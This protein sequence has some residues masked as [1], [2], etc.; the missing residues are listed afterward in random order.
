M[1][2]KLLNIEIHLLQTANDFDQKYDK[3]SRSLSSLQYN[4]FKKVTRDISSEEK[5]KFMLYD[6]YVLSDVML[7]CIRCYDPNKGDFVKYFYSA[8][9]NFVRKSIFKNSPKNFKQTYCVLSFISAILQE[10]IKQIKYDRI[11]FLFAATNKIIAKI[12]CKNSKL[13]ASIIRST[14]D[15][16]ICEVKEVFNKY[17]LSPLREQKIAEKYINNYEIKDFQIMEEL[18][19]KQRTFERIKRKMKNK[20]ISNNKRIEDA[21]KKNK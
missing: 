21:V 12:Y 20:V 9:N 13:D 15:N 10:A 14:A 3:I 19:I 6:Q 7:E 16:E 4:V 5:E 17:N 8:A 18:N 11:K 1:D 2:N